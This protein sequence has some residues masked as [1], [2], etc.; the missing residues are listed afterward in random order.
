MN[1][2]KPDKEYTKA[3]IYCRVSSEKQVKE[4]NGLDSQE[5]RCREYAASLG[6]G[7]D[8]VFRD[9]GISGGLFE[10]PAMKSLIRFLDSHWQNKYF[11]IFDDLKRF[12]RDVEVHIK[13]KSELMGRDAKLGCPNYNFDDS[14]EGE[15]V[16]TIFAAQNELERKQN[17]RQV[18]QKMKARLERGY[19]CFNQPAGY[20][21]RKSIEHGKIIVPIRQITD[22][23]AEGLNAFAEERLISQADVLRF[24]ESK[25]LQSFLGQK[26]LVLD[27]IK[28]ILTQPLYA[29]IVEYL[30]WGITRRRGLHESIISEATHEKILERL[31]RPERKP[32]E[33]DNLEFPLRRIVNCAVCGTK[34]TGSVSK[35]KYKYY[36]HYTCNNKNCQANP[37][38]I[39]A[40]KMEDDYIELLDK[41]KIGPELLEM[42]KIVATRIWEQKVKDIKLSKS[43]QEVEKRELEDLIDKYVN[44]I[45]QSKSE[46]IRE[47]YEAKIEGI[48]MRIKEIDTDAKNKKTPEFSEALNL[49]LRFLGTPAETWNN[50]SKQVKILLHNMIFTENLRYS[51]KG[52]FGTPKLSLP[53]GIKQALCVKKNNLVDP[54]GFEPLTFPTLRDAPV[55]KVYAWWTVLDL[56]Q[57]PHRCQRCAL[58]N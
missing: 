11:V 51:L 32:R 27:Q 19:W 10:R 35:G 9:E 26:K 42:G 23:L 4:G 20:E 56:N 6:L 49:T 31:K 7:V 15:F 45:P 3:V 34:M 46:S 48:D 28:T 40:S 38:N 52:G 57:R 29:G 2:T 37:K 41:I 21:F 50:S 33:T 5:H 39:T 44:L 12:A 36:P 30:E 13:L 18:C 55:N 8:N 24:F 16:E 17:R 25:Y 22:I 54:S 53:F 43:A 14:A 1:L 58:A 47:R